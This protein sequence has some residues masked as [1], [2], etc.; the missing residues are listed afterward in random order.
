M[1]LVLKLSN[2]SVIYINKKVVIQR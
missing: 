2:K 1:N